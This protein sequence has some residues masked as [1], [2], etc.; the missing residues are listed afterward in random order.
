MIRVVSFD[1][2][3]TLLR[4]NPEFKARRE[5]L[6]AEAFGADNAS[7]TRAMAVA[8]DELDTATLR[9][10]RQLGGAERL[11]RTAEIL[12]VPPLTGGALA[13]VEARMAEALR[14]DPP[15]L[16]EADVPGTLARIRAA[17]LGLAV[18]SNT[19]FLTGA[20]MRPTLAALGLRVDHHVFSN[21]V[22]HAKPA[23]AV[24]ARL[25]SLAG[26][27]P[28][29]I[30]HVGDNHTADVRG[31]RDA[32]LRALWYRPGHSGDGVIGRLTEVQERVSDFHPHGTTQA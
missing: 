13:Q 29:E 31:A 5:A 1:V 10:G 17:G 30:L 12:G 7:T 3:G 24:F 15:T 14:R 27:R 20:R 26:C 11:H 32:G 22:G 21:E 18:T 16:T 9:T 25:T 6:V 28:A 8:D 19:G 2:W 4:G 23:G